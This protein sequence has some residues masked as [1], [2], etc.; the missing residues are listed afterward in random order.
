V[1]VGEAGGV[2]SGRTVT[3]LWCFLSLYPVLGS[4]VCKWSCGCCL[5][6]VIDELGG[7]SKMADSSFL[8]E[9]KVKCGRSAILF[10]DEALLN[11]VRV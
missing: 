6:A 11:D 9:G 1:R 3:A 10:L 8:D 5:F 7:E 2:D 4:K